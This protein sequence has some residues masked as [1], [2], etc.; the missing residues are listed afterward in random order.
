MAATGQ[1]P[2]QRGQRIELA[3]GAPIQ[4]I[5]QSRLQINGLQLSRATYAFQMRTKPQVQL[6]QQAGVIYRWPEFR[7][8]LMQKVQS[9]A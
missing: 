8:Q 9:A 4:T 7:L 1:G 6:G 5:Q 2:T 3:A